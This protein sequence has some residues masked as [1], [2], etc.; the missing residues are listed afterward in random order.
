VHLPPPIPSL[1]P[2][3]PE[4][5]PVPEVQT[6]TEGGAPSG[7]QEE[8]TTTS[9]L[10][11]PAEAPAN[12]P[13]SV[14]PPLERGQ[15]TRQPRPYLEDFVC[16]CVQS[17]TYESLGGNRTEKVSGKCRSCEPVNSELIS[18]IESQLLG[19]TFHVN[20]DEDAVMADDL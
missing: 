1:I 13:V 20:D 17:G 7:E 16:D 9:E 8:I 14:S 18:R 6:L 5:Q 11:A 4:T 19:T 2:S 15:R 3:L 12:S 10:E